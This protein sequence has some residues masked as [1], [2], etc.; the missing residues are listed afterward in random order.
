MFIG[1]EL[2]ALGQRNKL[3]VDT[4]DR[5]ISVWDE[6]NGEYITVANYTREATVADIESLFD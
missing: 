1:T 2:P 5:E 6:E 4:D 3:Y